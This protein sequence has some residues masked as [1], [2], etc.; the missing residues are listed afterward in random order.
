ML[1]SNEVTDHINGFK[2]FHFEIKYP[3]NNFDD[4]YDQIV[5]IKHSKQ[6]KVKILIVISKIDSKFYKSKEINHITFDIS[7]NIEFDEF[8]MK[9]D[10]DCS[11]L[12]SI[13]FTSF[14]KNKIPILC[15]SMFS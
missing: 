3:S 7:N 6:D 15:D 9:F 11:S 14:H 1:K 2:D 8:D 12:E 10:K 13:S 5:E 4:I